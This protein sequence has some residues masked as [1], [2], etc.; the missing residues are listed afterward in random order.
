L[1]FQE[2]VIFV[3]AH[4]V[5]KNAPVIKNKPS[6]F[7]HLIFW[8]AAALQIVLVMVT[9]PS[10]NKFII[11]SDEINYSNTTGGGRAVEHPYKINAGTR[12]APA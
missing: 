11:I 2:L 7:V 6:S 5:K 10:C 12:P 4:E 3:E 8:Y 1:S 9:S